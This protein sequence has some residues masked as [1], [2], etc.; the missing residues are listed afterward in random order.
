MGKVAERSESFT[1]PARV[2]FVEIIA[3][4]ATA[5]RNDDSHGGELY[6]VPIRLSREPTE[7]WK[8]TF[9][10]TWD[11]PPAFTFMH[12][13]GI[14]RIQGDR[15]VMEGTTI[16]EIWQYHRV[17]LKFALNKANAVE[18]NT[19]ESEARQQPIRDRRLAE[20]RSH[21]EYVAKMIN[22]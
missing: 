22:L 21:V 16:G 2:R 15:V 17:I 5:P 11:R 1:H 8:R 7:I 19:W 13:P 4:E 14:V 18:Q 10:Q 12:R 3:S 6:T 9:I 20:H